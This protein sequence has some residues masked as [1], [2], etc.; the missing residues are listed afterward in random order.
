MFHSMIRLEQYLAASPLLR[1][2]L[3]NRNSVKTV[4]F[5]GCS[6]AAYSPDYVLKIRD[7]ISGKFGECEVFMACCAKPLKLMG[8]EHVFNKK[9]DAVRRG[10]DA[11]NAETVI[12]AC[13]N[14]FKILRKYDTGRNIISLWPL[15][16]EVGL[17][18]GCEGRYSG[19]RASIQDSCA[20]NDFPEVAEAVHK[21]LKRLGVTVHE[22]KVSGCKAKCCGGIAMLKT[23]C[24]AWPRLHDE[25]R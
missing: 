15:V 2:S 12:T 21:I 1:S 14:C 18:D 10:L 5:P 25:T 8:I 24:Q 3:R 6:L 16:Y 11:I 20:M 4:F 23:G 22:M 13:Q 7:F 19:M 17:P 9:I